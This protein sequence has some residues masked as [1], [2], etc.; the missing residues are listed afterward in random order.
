MR[1]QAVVAFVVFLVSISYCLATTPNP[2]TIKLPNDPKT[3]TQHP[4]ST[5]QI[6]TTKQPTTSMKWDTTSS[7]KM[8]STPETS[9]TTKGQKP[10]EASK[11]TTTK[12]TKP[13]GHKKTTKPLPKTTRKPSIKTKPKPS[14]KTTKKP[15]I[16]TTQK[17]EIPCE[18][19]NASCSKCLDGPNCVYC[20]SDKSCS[21]KKGGIVP[22]TDCEGNKW[23]WKQCKVPGKL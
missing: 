9:D 20:D 12:I 2:T 14:I 7:V 15:S 8:T 1:L 6:S 3:S 21:K 19:R 5:A 13:S 10:L 4:E 22:T 23:Y 16:K 17:P 18:L 11:P